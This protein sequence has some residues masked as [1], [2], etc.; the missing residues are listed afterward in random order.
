V[1]HISKQIRVSVKCEEKD[2]VMMI[3]MHFKC[4][5]S[6]L[7]GLKMRGSGQKASRAS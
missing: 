6:C 5:R 2:D 4:C 1:E 7:M 3:V